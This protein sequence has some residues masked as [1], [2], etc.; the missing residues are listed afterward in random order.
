MFGPSVIFGFIIATMWGSIF[1]FVVGGDIRQL[2]LFLLAGWVGFALGH[3]FGLVFG[4]NLMNIG[5]LRIVSASL[6]AVIALVA[7]YFFV[8]NGSYKR[9]IR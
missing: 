7:T 3:V 1:H 4:L 9:T 5:S 6:G 2:A 8:R